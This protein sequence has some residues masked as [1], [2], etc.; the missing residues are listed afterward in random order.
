[1]LLTIAWLALLAAAGWLVWIGCVMVVRPHRALDLLARTA[2][3]WRINAI[4]QVP[5][6]IAG[7]AMVVRA[8]VSRFPPFFELAGLFI[9]LS[10]VVLLVIPLRWHSGYALFWAKRIPTAAVRLIGPLSVAGG[11]GLIWAA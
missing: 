1:M 6:L 11:L 4:E 8:E 2:S 10:S 5:R 7:A 9:A 3:N